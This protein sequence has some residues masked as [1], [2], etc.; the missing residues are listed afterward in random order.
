MVTIGEKMKK[1]EYY[2]LG[3]GRLFLYGIWEQ[4][5]DLD[6]CIS[7][8]LF[9][10]VKDKYYLIESTVNECGAYEILS[11]IEMHVGKKEYFIRTFID[12]YPV[13]CLKQILDYKKNC[14]LPK[15]QIDIEKIEQYLSL[16]KDWCKVHLFFLIYLKMFQN[17]IQ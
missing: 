16:N 12:G 13:E 17:M 5:K 6:L 3:G 1:E 14:N 7:E 11:N 2:I 8:E 9:Q 10:V 4:T 15:D